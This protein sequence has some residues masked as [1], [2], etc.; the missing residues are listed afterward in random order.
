MKKIFAVFV[1]LMVGI[2]CNPGWA[3][4]FCI[5]CADDTLYQ[6]ETTIYGQDPTYYCKS[7]GTTHVTTSYGSCV[8]G[9]GYVLTEET[10]KCSNI[11]TY[12]CAQECTGCTACNST[13]WSDYKTGYQ[14]AITATCNCNTCNRITKYRCAAGYYQLSG[15]LVNCTSAGVCTGCTPCEETDMGTPTSPAGSTSSTA[16][17]IPS[18]TTGTDENGNSWKLTANCC[19]T[20]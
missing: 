6:Y 15:Q 4:E 5:A 11:T 16:C 13:V 9:S 2:N 10:D 8:S 19:D 1:F 12:T 3:A 20:D 7:D 18:G 17:C 14:S